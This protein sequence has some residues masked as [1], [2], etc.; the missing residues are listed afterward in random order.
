M[1]VVVD[2]VIPYFASIGLGVAV[3][4]HLRSVFLEHSDNNISRTGPHFIL[5]VAAVGSVAL[6]TLGSGVRSLS[7]LVLGLGTLCSARAGGR[8]LRTRVHVVVNNTSRRGDDALGGDVNEHAVHGVDVLAAHIAQHRVHHAATTGAVGAQ[9]A[10]GDARLLVHRHTGVNRR[11]SLA[12]TLREIQKGTQQVGFGGI[13]G[14]HACVALVQLELAV[15]PPFYP[16]PDIH[17]AEK[18]QFSS[19]KALHHLC[20]AVEMCAGD[21]LADAFLRH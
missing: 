19:L 3:Q 8:V 15:I 14:H 4:H 20:N 1:S 2:A 17:R 16:Q 13:F 9:D 7:L 12:H 18:A 5:T 10:G 21:I 11:F 6:Y